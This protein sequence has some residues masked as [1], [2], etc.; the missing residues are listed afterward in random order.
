M[1]LTDLYAH[2]R[3][4]RSDLC[5]DKGV[6]EIGG[7]KKVAPLWL[8]TEE[9]PK[10][11]EGAERYGRVREGI[12]V[13]S[14]G[15]ALNPKPIRAIVRNGLPLMSPE[16]ATKANRNGKYYSLGRSDLQQVVNEINQGL[17]VD[18][19]DVEKDILKMPL[20]N[21]VSKYTILLFGGDG[22]Q[23]QREKRVIDAKN[24]FYNEFKKAGKNNDSISL[25]L[26]CLESVKSG[27]S[28]G[29]QIFAGGLGDGFSP[30]WRG[31][32]LGLADG[33]FGV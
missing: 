29:T 27:E 6:A 21:F 16:Q 28:T 24:Y 17:I 33:V 10:M 1:T 30:R 4:K 23:E 26:S 8:V 5:F 32:G 15:Y 2:G 18:E 19:K 25:Y 20:D 12:V 14:A 7:P 22:P 9:R 31:Q 3:V 11:T 13:V